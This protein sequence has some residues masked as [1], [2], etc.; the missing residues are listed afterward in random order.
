MILA[1]CRDIATQ[2]EFMAAQQQGM[3]PDHADLMIPRLL[4]QR[5]AFRHKALPPP[6]KTF[7]NRSDEDIMTAF[8]F[9]MKS[10]CL[11]PRQFLIITNTQQSL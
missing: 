4:S 8:F 10:G 2:L 1:A 11:M 7:G 6:K 5:L 3:Q 9:I